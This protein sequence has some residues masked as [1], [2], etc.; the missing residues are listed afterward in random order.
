[1]ARAVWW[2]AL[3]RGA[4]FLFRRCRSQGDRRLVRERRLERV[5]S[6]ATFALGPHSRYPALRDEREV[7]T[8]RR[9]DGAASNYTISRNFR[10]TVKR[11][12]FSDGAR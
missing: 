12:V 8:E 6:R 5:E 4:S 10:V 9:S 11:L 3:T 1:M 2:P 7:R